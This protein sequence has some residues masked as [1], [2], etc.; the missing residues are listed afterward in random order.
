MNE[1]KDRRLP[2]GL[3]WL[4]VYQW[5][6]VLGSLGYSSV[7]AVV[8]V[9]NT[10]GWQGA[11]GLCALLILA[12]WGIAMAAASI[13][14]MRRRSRGPV[15]GMICHLLL[16]IPGLPAVLFFGCMYVLL[17]FSPSE[18]SRAWAELPLIFALMWLPF[19]LTSGWAFFYLRRLRSRSP[20]ESR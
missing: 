6:L 13:G 9:S 16:E 1:N 17:S 15:L 12:S 5:I 19:V 3:I 11:L 10:P 2:T 7:A 14:I 4:L 8:I 20:N 18:S